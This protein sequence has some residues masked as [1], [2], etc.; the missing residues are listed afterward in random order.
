MFRLLLLSLFFIPFLS[1]AQVKHVI[2]VYNYRFE[3]SQLNINIG[4]TI[5]WVWKEGI[6]TTT[7]ISLPNGGLPWS[8]SL[9]SSSPSFKYVPVETGSYG[10]YCQNHGTT[11][12]MTGM[13]GVWDPN[14]IEEESESIFQIFPNPASD[15][16]NVNSKE[17]AEGVEIYTI[18][19]KLLFSSDTKQLNYSL[20]ISELETG[21]Y[22]L[23]VRYEK[24]K[25]YT[26]RFFKTR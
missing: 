15:K 10:Y 21:A 4:D 24:D 8:Q 5:Q 2:E 22:L 7:S 16:L 20:D 6:H 25:H 18:E 17:L 19:G 1:G 12:N 26:G 13:F 3:P 14:G 11:Q 9:T 23:L